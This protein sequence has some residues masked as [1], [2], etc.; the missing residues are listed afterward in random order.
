[1]SGAA[2][3][4][5]R[6][7]R[8]GLVAATPALVVGGTLVCVFVGLALASLALHGKVYDQ[9]LLARLQPPFYS[10][11][12][13]GGHVLGTDSLGRDVLGRIMA[14]TR[15]SLEI[16][17]V[18]VVLGGIAGVALGMIAGYFG[19][20]VDDLLMRFTD[21][22]LAIPLVLFALSVIAVIGSGVRNLILVIAFTQW[23]TYARTARGETLVLR[24]SLFVTA[25]RSIGCG[26]IRI[27]LRHVLPHLLPSTIVL[28]TLN[29]STAVLLEAGLSFLGLGIAPPDP[30]LGSMLT[31]GRQYITRAPWLAIYPGLALLLLVLAI[32]LTGDGLRTRLDRGGSRR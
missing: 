13:S 31:E 24:E 7:R 5:R 18:A 9:D 8:E 2:I 16:A 17:V 20:W 23:M 22:V 27:L 12:G 28:A 3:L 10:H 25:A 14:G 26:H 6:R 21:A 15:I 1:M 4:G 19:G 29:V 11:G 30:S 32:N